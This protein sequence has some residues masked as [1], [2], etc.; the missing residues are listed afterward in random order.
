MIMAVARITV[1]LPEE[2]VKRAEAVG[3]SLD[4]VTSDVIELVEKRIE[5]QEAIHYLLDTMDALSN[6]P[7]DEKPT[8]EEIIEEVRQARREQAAERDASGKA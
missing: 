2:L 1:E 7:D 3:V 6:L 8:E 4:S 5:K